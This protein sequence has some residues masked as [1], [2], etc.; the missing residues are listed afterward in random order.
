M[1]VEMT[2][3]NRREHFDI[4]PGPAV[5]TGTPYGGDRHNDPMPQPERRSVRGSS[6]WTP[7]S[8]SRPAQMSTRRHPRQGLNASNAKEFANAVVRA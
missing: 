4:G 3:R 1:I 2:T 8:G 5:W 6:S 7:M